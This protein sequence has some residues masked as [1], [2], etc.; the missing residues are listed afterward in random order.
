VGRLALLLNIVAHRL[1]QSLKILVAATELSSIV[2]HLDVLGIVKEKLP[3]I[4]GD[5]FLQI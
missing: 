2:L 3:Q 1:H 4:S 5:Q